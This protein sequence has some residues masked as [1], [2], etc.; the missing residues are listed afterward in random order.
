MIDWVTFEADCEP[1][2]PIGGGRVASFNVDGELEWSVNK[3]MEVEGSGSSRIQLRSVTAESYEFSGNLVKFFQGHNVW[4]SNDLSALVEAWDRYAFGRGFPMILGSPVL[5]RVDVN[6]SFKFATQAEAL[7]W[8]RWAAQSAHLSH[9]G[10]GSLYKEGTVYWGQGSRR[11]SLK[12]YSKHVEV[13][14]TTK[15]KE[16]DPLYQV[17]KGIVRVEATLRRMELKRL[18]LANLTE[19]TPQSANIV[20]ML[21]L[22][23]LNLPENVPGESLLDVLPR[24]LHGPYAQWLHGRDPRRLY[25]RAT[26]YRYR[27]ALLEHGVD[28]FVPSA[29]PSQVGAHMPSVHSGWD[30]RK[31]EPWQPSAEEIAQLGFFNPITYHPARH[32]S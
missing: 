4:G 22:E 24:C 2:Q 27:L 8:I 31:L 5:K 29:E 25:S 18:N 1:H 16:G 21:F 23:R 6:A 28:I 32:C 13:V 7:E 17:T 15:A 19:W 10:R 30:I 12:A 20:L 11:S 3:R 26:A 14:S 9:R